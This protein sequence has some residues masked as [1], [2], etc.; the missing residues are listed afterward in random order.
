MS[1]HCILSERNDIV[2]C[3]PET[4]QAN[5]TLIWQ[6]DPFTDAKGKFPQSI[7]RP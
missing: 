5:I 4:Y 1:F 6:S 2:C 3:R 7:I